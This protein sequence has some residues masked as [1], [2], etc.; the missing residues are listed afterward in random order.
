MKWRKY[1]GK[2]DDI[3]YVLIRIVI[4]LILSLVAI[5]LAIAI[6]TMPYVLLGE[7]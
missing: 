1:V 5:F 6:I 3:A 4:I 7:Q 2:M